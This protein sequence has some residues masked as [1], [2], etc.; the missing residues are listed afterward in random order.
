MDL[1]VKLDFLRKLIVGDEVDTGAKG[2]LSGEYTCKKSRT[3]T[4]GSYIE[5]KEIESEYHPWFE[6]D[7]TETKSKPIIKLERDYILSTSS[8]KAPKVPRA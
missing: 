6:H 7:E 2:V 3:Q 4:G 8:P 5:W 1:H